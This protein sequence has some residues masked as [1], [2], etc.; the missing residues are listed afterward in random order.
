MNS[1]F[2]LLG[3]LMSV[4]L[5]TD[6]TFVEIVA[7]DNWNDLLAFIWNSLVKILGAYMPSGGAMIVGAVVLFILYQSQ[8]KSK[9]SKH[10][11]G[12]SSERGRY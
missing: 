1:S 9:R 6:P 3:L 10:H 4:A 7:A 11:R 12:E 5:A 8:K 2:T